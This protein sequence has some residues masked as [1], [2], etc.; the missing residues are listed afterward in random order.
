MVSAGGR[1]SGEGWLSRGFD[2]RRLV[3]VGFALWGVLV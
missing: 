2:V 1:G 3:V